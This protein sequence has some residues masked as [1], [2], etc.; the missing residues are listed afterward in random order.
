MFPNF[1]IQ[2]NLHFESKANGGMDECITTTCVMRSVQFIHSHLIF[3]FLIGLSVNTQSV[4]KIYN[5]L[6]VLCPDCARC[7]WRAC[8]RHIDRSI[9]FTVV[10]SSCMIVDFKAVFMYDFSQTWGNDF[11]FPV[12]YELG[13]NMCKSCSSKNDSNPVYLC[14]PSVCALDEH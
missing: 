7:F 14:S 1:P 4:L 8:D 9:F 5:E 11:V 6:H 3:C 2:E 12:V 10:H 13:Q